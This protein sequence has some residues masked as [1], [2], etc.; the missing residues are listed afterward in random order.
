MNL[1]KSLTPKDTEEIKPGLF[2]QR[3]NK[4]YRQIDPAAWNGKINWRNFLLGQNFLRNFIW[5][6]IIIF[7]AWSYFHDVKAY[8]DFYTDVN[9]N[10]IG[11]CTN[12]S[13]VNTDEIQITNTLQSNYRESPEIILEG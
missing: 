1:T 7:L 13:L 2:I 4:G 10:P 3:T 8:R 12:V 9:S 11:F 5:F 6:A